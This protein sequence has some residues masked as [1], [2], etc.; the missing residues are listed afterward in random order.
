MAG[1]Q[2]FDVL[3]MATG[4]KGPKNCTRIL[5]DA[6]GNVF[7]SIKGAAPVP[8][9]GLTLATLTG[10]TLAALLSDP[11]AIE[12]GAISALAPGITR[13]TP[14]MMVGFQPMS[15]TAAPT[16]NDMAKAGSGLLST[17]AGGANIWAQSTVQN[18]AIQPFSYTSTAIMA[19]P[20]SGRAQIGLVR[21][22]LLYILAIGVDNAVSTTNYCIKAT[23]AAPVVTSKAVD[24]NEHMFSIVGNGLG[25]ATGGI[26]YGLIDGQLVGQIT[27]DASFTAAPLY[28]H[29][30]AQNAGGIS[31][32]QIMWGWAT[33]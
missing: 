20:G 1:Q 33:P 27:M 22:D 24:G 16:A 3:A 4:V 18:S 11:F 19:P 17:S 30:G 25:I 6:N 13:F 26:L 28:P 31:T 21:A 29:S 5:A 2:Y 7:I 10:A 32:Q 12:A 9:A 23:G 15:V 14:P 8:I